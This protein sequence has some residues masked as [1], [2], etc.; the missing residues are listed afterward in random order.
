M[1]MLLY[2]LRGSLPWQG[3][4]IAS[5]NEKSQQICMTKEQLTPT[6]LF[7]GFPKE[8]AECME[9]V[10]RL[11]YDEQPDYALLRRR[12]GAVFVREDFQLDLQFDWTQHASSPAQQV[13]MKRTHRIRGVA[14]SQSP[15]SKSSFTTSTQTSDR[16][17]A[18]QPSLHIDPLRASSL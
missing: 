6:Q 10:R 8:F 7:A 14:S 4:A 13:P 11:R 15:V 16:C 1:Y 2:F 5:R 12:L 18:T 3:M 17:T 9:Y